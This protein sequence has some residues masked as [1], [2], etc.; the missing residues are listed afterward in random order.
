MLSPMLSLRIRKDVAALSRSSSVTVVI[1]EVQECAATGCG[2]DPLSGAAYNSSCVACNGTG[3]TRSERKTDVLCRISWIDSQLVGIYQGV[4]TG[5]EGDL[6]IQ[7]DL[8]YHDL[9]EEA[10]RTE[11]AY[12]LLDGQT[13]T[14]KSIIINR[15]EKATSL[16][17]RCVRVNPATIGA[18]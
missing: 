15:V 16:D 5:R 7:A 17:I 13:L 18:S 14:P 3:Q 11:G 6:Q 1:P 10:H 4:P 8:E 2:Y 9:F 12:I